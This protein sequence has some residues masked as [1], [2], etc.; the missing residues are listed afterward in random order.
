M[1]SIFKLLPVFVALIGIVLR[2]VSTGLENPKDEE[3]YER[4]LLREKAREEM[5]S[6]LASL[7]TDVIE[8]E[9]ADSS[10]QEKDSETGEESTVK[11]QGGAR[12]DG[13][14]SGQAIENTGTTDKAETSN[15]TD[16]KKESP[17]AGLLGKDKTTKISISEAIR[18]KR[19]RDED[20]DREVVDELQ[21]I[22]KD[23]SNLGE[24][25]EKAE[26][27]IDSAFECRK[28]AKH[29]SVATVISGILMFLILLLISAIR[30]SETII[31]AVSL[32]IASVPALV[33]VMYIYK[34]TNKTNKYES[35]FVKHEIYIRKERNE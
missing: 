11:R 25:L 30:S 22:Q 26:G 14:E 19:L 2:V 24:D 21:E 8:N 34:Y 10:E 9:M 18:Q 28:R 3:R 7:I 35:I 27:L 33:T 32:V 5:L 17:L 4:T 31:V 12:S 16:G 20:D 13:G 6:P 15:N 1:Y 29:G 23:I